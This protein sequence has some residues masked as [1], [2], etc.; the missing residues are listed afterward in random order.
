MRGEIIANTALILLSESLVPVYA[1]L[2]I[3]I[4]DVI[5]NREEK[6]TQGMKFVVG[7]IFAITILM[8][9]VLRNFY[10]YKGSM[11][12]F[13][14]RKLL[15]TSLYDKVSKLSMRSLTSVLT[16]KAVNI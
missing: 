11:V 14:I 3:Y 5:F 10:R 13:R 4:E 1:Y 9:S 16:D 2:L 8:S 6:Y 15:A 12:A 7:I